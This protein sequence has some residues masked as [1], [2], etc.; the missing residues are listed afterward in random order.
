MPEP[1]GTLEKV[2]LRDVWESEP[3]EFTPWLAT[4]EGIRILGETI[5]IDL[6]LEAQE[7]NVGPFRADILC[8]DTGNDSWVLIENQLAVTD[9]RHLGQLL[10][11]A[12]GLHAV[13]V[14]WVAAT[15]TEEHRATL[16]WLNEITDDRFQFFGLEIELWRIGNSPAAPKLNIVSKP[17]DWSRS[18]SQSAKR[19]SD[20]PLNALQETQLLYWSELKSALIKKGSSIHSRKPLPQHWTT[21]GSGV[22]ASS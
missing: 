5:K 14:V 10:T 13:T 12:A 22:Q 7:K 3:R 19:I 4:E 15:F 20:E 21:Y 6:V 2:E 18:V 8:K 1:L 11:Y 17:N 16:D 9:H